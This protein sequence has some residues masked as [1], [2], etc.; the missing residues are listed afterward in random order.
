[1]ALYSAN[2]DFEEAKG[3]SR[4]FD[5]LCKALQAGREVGAYEVKMRLLAELRAEL[6]QRKA[7]AR[8]GAAAH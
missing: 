7:A 2:R 6:K 1:M 3:T 5:T 8:C 4:E